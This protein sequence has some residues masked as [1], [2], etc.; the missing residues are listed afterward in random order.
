MLRCLFDGA[1]RG[2]RRA[3]SNFAD[4]VMMMPRRRSTQTPSQAS[5]DYMPALLQFAGDDGF[6]DAPDIEVA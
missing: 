2:L 5:D 1:I 4:A 6:Q 3:L